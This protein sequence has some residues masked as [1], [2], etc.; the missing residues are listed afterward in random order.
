[1]DFKDF[2]DKRI[3]ILK[4]NNGNPLKFF[5]GTKSHFNS[6]DSVMSKWNGVTFGSTSPEVASGYSGMTSFLVDSEKAFDHGITP[7]LRPFYVRSDKPFNPENPKHLDLI[8]E[9][10]KQSHYYEKPSLLKRVFGEDKHI[11]KLMSQNGNWKILEDKPVLEKIKSLGFDG[12]F[13]REGALNFG[14]FDT[15]NIISAFEASPRVGNTASHISN[16]VAHASETVKSGIATTSKV[17][18]SFIK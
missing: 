13:T 16:A 8:R 7:N 6:F 14:T 5:H 2:S 1:M 12:M 11:N 18:K 17:V 4:D 10:I 15:K 3:N 9:D